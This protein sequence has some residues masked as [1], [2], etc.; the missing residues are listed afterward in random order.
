MT[1]VWTLSA[2]P[3]AGAMVRPREAPPA[4][5]GSGAGPRRKRPKEGSYLFHVTCQ[6]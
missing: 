6:G 2:P 1:R 4:L 5:S 3:L